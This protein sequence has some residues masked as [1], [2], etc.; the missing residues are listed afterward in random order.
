MTEPYVRPDVAGMF[1]QFLNSRARPEMHEVHSAR[2][3]GR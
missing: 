2:G 3:A 1:L